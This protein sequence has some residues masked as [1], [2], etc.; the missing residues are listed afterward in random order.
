MNHR[1]YGDET[2]VEDRPQVNQK[3]IEPIIGVSRADSISRTLEHGVAI[4]D[5]RVRDD[6]SLEPV[7]PNRGDVNH[8][9]AR[10]L[11]GELLIATGRDHESAE[12]AD[13][14][15]RVADLLRDLSRP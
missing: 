15:L 12:L 5:F 10:V 14:P 3:P 1:D 7:I 6:G 9:W 11:V 8:T 4:G 13:F 2:D